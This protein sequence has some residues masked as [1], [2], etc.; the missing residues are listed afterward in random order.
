MNLPV[1]PQPTALK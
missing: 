1:E